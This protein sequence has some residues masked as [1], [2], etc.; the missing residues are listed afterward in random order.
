[1]TGKEKITTGCALFIASSI[2]GWCIGGKLGLGIASGVYAY[3]MVLY[4]IA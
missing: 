2:S 3:L 4:L 1:M